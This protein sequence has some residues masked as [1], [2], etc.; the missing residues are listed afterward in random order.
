MP[1][2]S[3]QL[4]LSSQK[5]AQK[6]EKF[7][8]DIVVI[9]CCFISLVLSIIESRLNS[10]AHHWGLMYANAAD[11]LNG[12]IP[13]KQIFIQYGFLTTLIQSDSLFFFGNKVVSVG[14]ITGLFYSFNIYL[15]YCLWQK[16]LNKW[17][18]ALSSILMFLVQGYIIYPWANYFY[19]TFLLISLLFLTSSI[20]K[21]NKYFLAGM[22]MGFSFLA[23]QYVLPI[24]LPIYLYFG[25][26]YFSSEEEKEQKIYFKNFLILNTGFFSVITLFLFYIIRESAL[27]DWVNQSFT[28]A[29][30]Y[31][32]SSEQVCVYRKRENGDH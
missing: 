23:R 11:L 32:P 16:V 30:F 29:K 31:V 7:L 26:L 9:S 3:E 14:I 28:I 21:V 4:K 10:D 6:V 25:L 15:S 2:Y 19:Y 13:Y 1:I 24:I 12:L 18:A 8:P 27:T 22:F 20:K 5:I 17:L